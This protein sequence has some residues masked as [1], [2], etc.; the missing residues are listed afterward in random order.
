MARSWAGQRVRNLVPQG[1]GNRLGAIA[2][3]EIDGQLNTPWP[4]DAKPHCGFPPVEG[5]RP[6]RKTVAGQQ[7][8]G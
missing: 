8:N 7:L 1:L 3:D 2:L 6:I 4:V 5:K